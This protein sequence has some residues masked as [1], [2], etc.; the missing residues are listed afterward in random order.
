MCL[1]AGFEDVAVG[2]DSAQTCLTYSKGRWDRQT[3][4]SERR[5][6]RKRGGAGPVSPPAIC[7]E[8]P[9]GLHRPG[10]PWER[11]PNGKGRSYPEPPS[12]PLPGNPSRA[13][14]ATDPW[15]LARPGGDLEV[16]G[17]GPRKPSFNRLKNVQVIYF[18]F[19]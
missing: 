3:H 7:A 9:M 2:S 8:A 14:V 19:E 15:A 6:K 18:F 12:L 11:S 4:A 10:L 1:R 13:G 17:R 5:V 16:A